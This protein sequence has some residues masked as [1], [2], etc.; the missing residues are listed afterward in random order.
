M[1][2]NNGFTDFRFIL[3]QNI[4]SA[5]TQRGLFIATAV[6]LLAIYAAC[7]WLTGTK[8]GL[9]QRAIRDS[10]NRVLFSGYPVARYQAVCLC[11]QRADRGDRRRALRAA[12]AADQSRAK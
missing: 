6:A 2:G 3:G 1:G 8:F 7:R 10:E 12:G 11:G 5:G 9:I 4:R